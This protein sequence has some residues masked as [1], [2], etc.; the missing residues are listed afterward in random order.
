[1]RLALQTI[2]GILFAGAVLSAC[3]SSESSMQQLLNQGCNVN[4]PDPRACDPA[5]TKKTT[6]CHIPPGNPANAHTI[7]IGNAAVPAHLNN[8]GDFIG[9]CSCT[10]D[11]GDAG[12]GGDVDA[13]G[14]GGDTDAGTPPP[15][16]DDGGIVL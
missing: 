12:V 5:D 9:T 3:N 6:V 7:C 2:T 10:G 1:M 14:G 16:S 13:G 11:S 4:T 8:H 15:S